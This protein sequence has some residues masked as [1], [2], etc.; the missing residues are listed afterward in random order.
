MPTADHGLIRIVIADDHPVFREGLVKLLQAKPELQVV[1]VAADGADAMARS[2]AAG[3]LVEL[4]AI[5]SV[6]RTLGAPKVSEFTLRHV[7]ELVAEVKVVDDAAAV[8]ALG[9]S[10]SDARIE[11]ALLNALEDEDAWVRYYACQ[12][13]GRLRIETAV[14]GLE[15]LLADPAGQVRVA[16]IEGLSHFELDRAQQ[17]LMTAARAG[18]DDGA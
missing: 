18:E 12:S 10:A 9:N 2:L 16:A 4:P 1:G 3:E 6:A 5:T 15:R 7:R 11:S 17:A 13:A 14:A 8:R